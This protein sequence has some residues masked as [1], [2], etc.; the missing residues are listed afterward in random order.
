[1][2]AVIEYSAGKPGAAV[3]R[4]EIVKVFGRIEGS[5]SEFA[6]AAVATI[7]SAFTD[8]TGAT[9]LI[10]RQCTDFL[11]RAHHALQIIC[12]LESWEVTLTPKSRRFVADVFWV[13]LGKP[14]RSE[15]ADR[16]YDY[17]S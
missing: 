4:A 14:Y 13:I 10:A 9:P 11:V 15:Q 6:L 1:M 2:A 16:Y 3:D 8:V 5:G 12:R 7:V 17:R